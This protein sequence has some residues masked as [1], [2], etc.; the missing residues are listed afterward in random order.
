[1]ESVLEAI[2]ALR[3]E[4]AGRPLAVLELGTGSGAIPLAVCSEVSGL[5]WVASERSTL[6]LGVARE[7][8]LRHQALLG[9]KG[10]ALLLL[11]GDRFGAIRPGWRP[12]VIAGNPPYIPSGTIRRLMPEVS[13]AEPRLALDG[14]PDGTDFQRYL[15]DYAA[16]ALPPGG[17]LLLEMGA[18]QSA[19]LR[20]VLEG[21]PGLRLV[22]VVNDLAGHPRVLHGEKTDEA[23]TPG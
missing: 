15:I 19:A 2:R 18:E 10:N 12:D 1:V 13:Q 4:A 20:R 21:T 14:G 7:N 23:G 3:R 16:R 9:P 8:R 22:E 6:A 11:Q 5:T 17:R